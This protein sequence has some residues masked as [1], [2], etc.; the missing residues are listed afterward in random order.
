MVSGPGMLSRV[1]QYMTKTEKKLIMNFLDMLQVISL[2]GVISP[3]QNWRHV[4]T[5]R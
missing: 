1:N 4:L 2:N 5:K 3:Y